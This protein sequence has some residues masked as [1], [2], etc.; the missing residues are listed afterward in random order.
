MALTH[1][2]SPRI[3]GSCGVW[4]RFS[5]RRVRRQFKRF[6]DDRSKGFPDIHGALFSSKFGGGE[7]H[8]LD[9]RVPS[10]IPLVLSAPNL[11]MPK[12]SRCCTKKSSRRYWKAAV[13]IY[14]TQGN[15]S[16]NLNRDTCAS[17]RARMR[18]SPPASSVVGHSLCHKLR[19]SAP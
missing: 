11:L 14:S 12:T 8:S 10:G 7:D 5:S 6:D 2:I 13:P 18:G 16:W 17:T 1:S 19:V 4:T 15:G 9:A 3:L